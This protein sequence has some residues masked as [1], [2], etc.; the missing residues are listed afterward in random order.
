[1]SFTVIRSANSFKGCGLLNLR[2]VKGA[3][4]T[5]CT[6]IES[7]DQVK[8]NYMKHLAE[9][10]NIRPVDW[11]SAKPFEKIPGIFICT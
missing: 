8:L 3:V 2:S 1:M 5:F 4:S 10:N 11:D 6:K 9:E 7:Q